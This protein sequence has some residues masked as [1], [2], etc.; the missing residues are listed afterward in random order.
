MTHYRPTRGIVRIDDLRFDP[1]KLRHDLLNNCPAI[2]RVIDSFNAKVLN[3]VLTKLSP[4]GWAKGPCRA[5]HPS[6]RPS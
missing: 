5:P 1:E 4:G 3:A 2:Q 6:G